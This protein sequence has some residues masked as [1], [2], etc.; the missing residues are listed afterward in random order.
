[1]TFPP[2][3]TPIA[4]NGSTKFPV[5]PDTLVL[6]NGATN[7][8]SEARYSNWE[9][10]TTYTIIARAPADRIAELEA[11]LA[12]IDAMDPESMI[13]GCS[14]DAARGLV[15]R[16]GNIARATLKGKTDV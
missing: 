1:M 11:A 7:F 13:A 6:V 15:S 2:L 16:M 9:Y 4:H 8:H 10:V 12:L 5:H 14:A 3:N